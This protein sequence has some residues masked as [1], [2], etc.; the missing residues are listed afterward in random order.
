AEILFKLLKLVSTP[1]VP[2]SRNS[3]TYP[4]IFLRISAIVAVWL[5]LLAG[6]ST[7]RATILPVSKTGP[8]LD[9][10]AN[11]YLVRTDSSG[12]MYAEQYDPAGAPAYSIS[13]GSA[14]SLS[15]MLLDGTA[16]LYL[17]RTDRPGAMYAE[18][19]NTAGALVYVAGLA[20]SNVS[21]M[22]LD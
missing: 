22:L 19:Y 3:M 4:A 12:A 11:L 15:G 20:A 18:K 9:G 21:R 16:N 5:A 13:F 1:L 10:S 14:R 2:T 8:L 6:P 7:D 17:V